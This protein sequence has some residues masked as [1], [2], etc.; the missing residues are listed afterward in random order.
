MITTW[1]S[2]AT[3]YRPDILYSHLRKSENLQRKYCL[4]KPSSFFW[5]LKK[6]I[7]F[8]FTLLSYTVSWK[9]WFIKGHLQNL[10]FSICQGGKRYSAARS[11]QK[12]IML[13]IGY[14]TSFCLSKVLSY[15]KAQYVFKAK[16]LY[17]H[18]LFPVMNSYL[19]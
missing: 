2:W 15:K 17:F 5:S 12:Q 13:I 1:G 6:K 19:S 3:N 16:I 4:N 8:Y 7:Q 14:I 10:N 9:F 11:Q 18:V